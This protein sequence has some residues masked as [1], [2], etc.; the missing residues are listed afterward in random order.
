MPASY[1]DEAWF[2]IVCGVGV[3]EE[4]LRRFLERCP[5][6]TDRLEIFS[7]KVSR[8]SKSRAAVSRGRFYSWRPKDRKDLVYEAC[9]SGRDLRWPNPTN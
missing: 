5:A 4:Q 7:L 1:A 9:F 8:G 3:R 2:G 6:N